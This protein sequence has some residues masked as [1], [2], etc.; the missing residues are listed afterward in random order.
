[1]F[2][3]IFGFLIS[4]QTFTGIVIGVVSVLFYF[5]VKD[6]KTD[7]L[8]TLEKK[9]KAYQ[10]LKSNL[11]ELLDTMSGPESVKRSV[12]KKI[13]HSVNNGLFESKEDQLIISDIVEAHSK[14]LAFGET[15]SKT[16]Y[17]NKEIIN[18]YHN[19]VYRIIEKIDTTLSSAT[20]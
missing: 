6:R 16:P 5:Y 10:I 20:N 7:D 3:E 11:N 4:F 9:F 19:F 1:M 8:T 15:I 18:D 12:S 13:K 14:Y 2:S 17:N